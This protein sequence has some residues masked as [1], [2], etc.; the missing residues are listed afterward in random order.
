MA[1]CL[2]TGRWS[3]QTP[4]WIADHIVA[5]LVV[6]PGA[7][8]VE[9]ALHVGRQLECDLLEEL[10]M[11]S[12][13]VF[14]EEDAVHLQVSIDSL[15]DT[16]RR[17][18]KVY[19]RSER[20][21]MD[22]VDV[23][24]V[25]TRHAS[26]VL[27]GA[28]AGSPEQAALSERAAAL[29]GGDWPP[30]GAV[31]VDVDG[32]Y[33][34]MA[35]IGFDYGPA[36][37][38]VRSLWRHGE[39]VLVEASLPEGERSAAAS[40][41]I[42]PALL[43][44]VLQGMV[45]LNRGDGGP[46]GD[47]G[48]LRLP[49]AFNGVRLFARGGALLRA[50]LTPLGGDAMSM[51]AVDE[52]GEV[53]AS[54]LSL[55]PRAT[56]R[57][58]LLDARGGKRESL[59]GLRWTGLA[60]AS[61][62]ASPVEE[63]AVLSA[64]PTRLVEGFGSARPDVYKDFESL[65][66]AAD[67]GRA[68]PRVVVF[69][70]DGENLEAS[71]QQALIAPSAQ[72]AHEFPRRLLVLLQRWLVDERFSASSLVLVTK[73]A[74]SVS[75]EEDVPGLTQTPVWGLVRSAQLEHPGRFVLV[76]LD[77][78][79]GSIAALPAA[80][81]SEEPQIAIRDGRQLAPRLARLHVAGL[82][83][84]GPW[85]RGEF[86]PDG[87]I[88]ITGGTGALGALI[89]RRLVA[90]HGARRLLLA[91]RHGQ[92]AA[93]AKELEIELAGLGAQVRIEACDVADRAQLES[94][95]GSIEQDR[96]LTAVLHL[97]GV[98][99]DGTITSLSPERLDPVLA[100]KVDAALHL[101]ELTSHLRLAAFV[102]FSSVTGTLGSPGQAGYAAAN[103]FLDGLAAY[104]R[105]RGLPGT[106][107]AW[108][109]W[110]G[111]RGMGARLGE[112]DLMR[113]ERFGLV[114]LS[115]EEGLELCDLA[116]AADEALVLP[117][118]LDAAALRTE[119]ENRSLHPLLG[120]LVR[121][122]ARGASK[123]TGSLARRLLELAE[124][125]REA[126]ML[127]IVR[128]EA[129]AV[130]GAP[131]PADIGAR[132]QLKELGFDSLM[133]VE[134]RNRLNSATGLRLPSTL[135]FD[136]P[137]PAELA[138][139]LAAELS[140]GRS[141][142]AERALPSV[143]ALP[144]EEPIA[145]VGMSCRYPG[146]VR[147]PD[148]L[149]ELLASNSD[150]IS[151]FPQDRGWD[152][153]GLYDPDAA[154]PGTSYAREGGFLDDAAEF[155]AA[156][157]GISPREALAMD[158]QQRVLLEA[159]WEALENARIDPISLRGSQTGVFAGIAATD[160][161][162]GLWAAPRGLE[163]LAG[164]WLTGS[165]GSIVSGRVAYVLGLEGPAV[166]VD[167]AC[168]SSLVAL[169]LAGQALRGG[170]CTM[171]LAGGVT[172]MDSPG[173]FAQFSGQR[174]LARDGRC[175][176]FADSADGVGWGE[177]VGIVVLERLSEAQRHGHRVLALLSASAV[178]Q[179]GASNGLT[180]PNGPSQ[181]RVIHQALARAGLSPAQVDAVEGHGTGTTLGDPIEAQALIATYGQGRRHD[182]PLWL[183]SIK[184][185]IGHTAAA[186]GVAGVI[187]MTMALQ[188]KVLPA[189]LH[190]D[191]PSSEVDWST[192]SVALLTEARP[193]E[194]N[195]EPRRA[196]V[197]S[198]GISGT[199][200]HVI[201]QE[202]PAYERSP[203][204]LEDSAEPS[205]GAPAPCLL[206]AGSEPGLR[207]QARRLLD[208]LARHPDQ[209]IAD[210]GYSLTDRPALQQR[211]VVLA[212][213][214]EE[215]ADGLSALAEGLAHATLTR[216]EAS[217][218]GKLAFLFTGQGAQRVGM[219]RGLYEAYS[220]FA[221]P[222]ERICEQFGQPLGSSVLEL[223][224]GEPDGGAPGSNGTGVQG[225]L[226][227]TGYAQPAL[228]AFEVALF[229][230]IETWGV[231]PD[232][233]LGHS[234]GELVAAHV[235]GVLS[236]AD[237][238]TLVAARGR[239]MDALPPGGAMAAV[240][241][242]E[243]EALGS[244]AEVPGSVALAAVNGPASVVLSG[245]EEAISRLSAAWELRGRKTRRL[246]V[247][248][249]FHSP[250]MD[251]ML[252][253]FA[254]EARSV[255]LA[256]PRI[257][258]VSNVTG[259]IAGGEMCDPDYWARHARE[260]VR[261]ADG[262]RRLRAAGA[263]YLLE[264]GPDG[265]LSAMAR[266]CLP[267]GEGV[268]APLQRRG[269]SEVDT[270][271]AGLAEVWTRG[272]SVDWKPLWSAH[273]ARRLELPTYAFQRSRY[274]LDGTPSTAG[275]PTLFGQ[276]SAGHPLL[277]ATVSL[278]QGGGRL[279]TGRVSL[280]THAWLADHAVLGTVLMPGTALVE[281]AL[282]AG[283][284]LGCSCLQELALEAPLAIPARGGVQLQVTVGEPD[285]SGC[286]SVSVHSRPDDPSAEIEAHGEDLWIRHAS[287]TL[288][289]SSARD[290]DSQAASSEIAR[291]WPPP[292]AEPL[293]IEDLYERLGERG[294]AY[295]P[296]FQGV[297]AAWR[298]GA[299]LFAEVILPADQRDQAESFNLHPALLDA[300]LHIAIA[301]LT[302]SGS[303]GG[304]RLPFL[305]RGVDLHAGGASELLVCLTPDGEDSLSLTVLDR[306]GAPV[307]DID[308]LRSRFVEA[309]QLDGARSSASRSLFSL[310]WVQ[311]PMAPA[312]ASSDVE[313]VALDG[314]PTTET[315]P[316]GARE[317][318]RAALDLLRSRL[319]EQGPP[320]SRFA[321][322]TQGALLAG[323]D[324]RAPSLADAAVWGLARGAQLEHPGRFLLVDVD[325]E[326]R[327][328][329]ALERVLDAAFEL[330][331]SQLAVRA[332]SVLVPRLMAVD[333]GSLSAEVGGTF[334]RQGGTVLVTGG[335]GGLGAV[336][337]R[338]LVRK[339][340]VDRLLL[341]GRRGLEAPG[342]GRLA[343]ELSAL[344]ANVRVAA[345]DVS[346]RAE[347]QALLASVEV[348][349]PLSGMVHAAGVLDDGVIDSL[350]AERLDGVLAPKL[351][352]A[353][354]LH[355]LTAGLDLDA[356]VSFSSIAG[357][358]GSPGQANY[359]A[360]NAF[361]DA[362]AQHR[363]SLG[364]PAVSLVWGAWEQDT[365]MT[366]GL[367]E[368]DRARVARAGVRPLSPEEG[369]QLFDLAHAGERA[370]ILAA[371]LDRS[372][373]RTQAKAGTL[374][375]ALR[376]IVPV[377]VRRAADVGAGSLSRLVGEASGQERRRIVLE[378]VRAETAGVLGHGSGDAIGPRQ[379]FKEL[380][381]D[382]L[383]A[384]ELRNR[385]GTLTGLSL[386][387]TLV[388]DYPNPTAL[389]DHLLESVSGEASR[390]LPAISAKKAVD[391]PIAI[392]GMSC[393]YP[394]GV[395]SPE[396]LWRLT[397]DGADAISPFP[398]DRGWNLDTLY[399]PDPDHPGT[400]YAMEGGFMRGVGDFD[401]EFFG[402]GPRE[403]LA[404][405]P[406]QRLL[407]EVSWEALEDAGIAPDSLRGSPTGVFAGVMYQDYATGLADSQAA[408]LEGYRATGGAGSV[409]SGRVAYTLGLE[410]P[411]VSIDTACSSSLVALHWAC[412][413]LASGECSM[414]LASGVTVLWTPGVFVEFSRQ[415]GL[416]RDGRCK[417]Y[418]DAAD[419][420]GW[421]E[422]VGVLVL[423]RL[424]EAERKGHS[425]LAV[426]RGSAVNQDGASNGLAAPNGPSQQNVIH[427]ALANARVA[428]EQVDVVEGHGTGTML[429]DPIEA[430]ALLATYGQS[431]PK[432]RPLWLGS[433]KS[434][435][436]HTQAA[437]GVAGVIKMAMAM[438]HEVLP[439][440][441]HVEQ[442]S[443]E[444][445]WSA[446]A[447]SLLSDQ[448]PWPRGEQT[449]RAGVS[450]FG[451]SGT[452][453]H[454][455]LEEPP[456][457]A[458][459]GAEDD[460][461]AVRT[462]PWVLSGRSAEALR[463][464][465]GRL[466]DH[467]TG[468]KDLGVADV[469][470]SLTARSML[471]CRAVVVGSDR[472]GLLDGVRAVARGERA[473]N[474]VRG[475]YEGP[476]DSAAGLVAFLFTGQGA[477]HVG[478]GRELYREL[479]LYRHAFDETCA[480]LEEHLTGSVKE[481]VLGDVL[482]QKDR[483]VEANSA[484]VQAT[485]SSPLDHTTLAQAA[486]F[487]LEVALFRVLES[488]GVRPDFLIGHSVGELAAA[489]VSGVF[490][491]EDAC[492]LVAARGRLM[493][494]L[495]PGGAMV[496]VQASEQEALATLGDFEGSVTL[497]AVNGPSSVVL[498][499]DEDAVSQLT[500]LW[501]A[502]SRKTKRLR[503]SHAFH[504]HHMDDMLERF[505]E[506]ATEVSFESPRIPIVSNLTGEP[507]GADLLCT[508]D[509]WVRH[510]RETVRFGDG[511]A[512]LGRQG[513][514]CLLELGPD[515]VLSAMAGE[516]LDEED[517][518]PGS[519]DSATR[520]VTAPLL[521]GDRPEV[522]TLVGSLAEAFVAG[523]E[524]DWAST[525]AE[526]GARRV[527]LPT[528]AFQR[529][530]YWVAP[531]SGGGDVAAVGQSPDGHPLLGAA[532]E[533]A[534]ERGGL[535]TGRISVQTHPWLADHAAM[536]SVLL[537]GMAY[538]DLA[539][540]AGRQIGADLVSEL[541][542]EVP[543]VMDEH[544]SVLLQVSVGE[545]DELGR[546]TVD[547][548]SRPTRASEGESWEQAWTRHAS[549]TLATAVQ[550]TP[551][552]LGDPGIDAM[553]ESWPPRG[554]ER[555]DITGAYERLADH[556]L[557][558]GPAFQG[559]R[560]VWRTERE[561]FA[562]VSLP[563]DQHPQAGAFAIH[564]ALLDAAFHAFIDDGV[565]ALEEPRPV[566]LPFSFG[567]VGLCARGAR[568]LRVRLSQDESS[569]VSL[570][571][572]DETGA[573]VVWVDSLVGREVSRE[574]L[575]SA[576]RAHRDSLFD[577]RWHPIASTDLPPQSAVGRWVVL[578]EGTAGISRA[579]R[580]VSI[581]P[582]EHHTAESLVNALEQGD[583]PPEV[584][585]VDC[586]V[587]L[588]ADGMPALLRL[589]VNRALETL[590]GWLADER[591]SG[592]RLVLLTR[593]A[594]ATE[595]GA[596][597]PGLSDAALW[598]LVQSAQ[599]ENPGR[600]VLVDHD[601]E[602]S[603]WRALAG[604]LAGGEPRLALR[605]GNVLVP[606]LERVAREASSAPMD[607]TALEDATAAQAG[608]GGTPVFDP[609]KT[610]LITGGTGGLGALM[611]RHLA[612]EHGARN[613][614]LA[615]RRG[616]EAPGVGEL[617]D[618][619]AQLGAETR[620]AACDV[621]VREQLERLLDSI[622]EQHPL[623]AVVHTAAIMDNGLV[624]SLTPEQIDRVLAAKAD[625]AW[626]LHE[627]TAELDLSAFVLFSSI[628]GLFGGPGQGNY[629]AANVFL[630]GLAVHRRAQGL[631][632]TSVAWSLWS[633]AGA[634]TQ[635]GQL[636][637]RRVVG[638]AGLS[639][640][641]SEQ[642]LE[643]FDLAVAG[644]AATVLAAPMDLSALRA[645]ARAGTVVPLLSGLVPV[646]A[647]QMPVSEEGPL[648][649]RLASTP[650]DEREALVL[651]VVRSEA[652]EVLGHA[653]HE[654]ID[655]AR[656]FKEAGFDSLAAV[657]L[658]NR[659][660]A[661]TGLRLPAT[662]VF[663]RPSPR[664]L[665]GYLLGEMAQ[666]M[667]GSEAWVEKA[668][669]EVERTIAQLAGAGPD[670]RRVR[671][672]LNVC[673]AALGEDSVEQ[674]HAEDDFESATDDEMFEI[675]DTEL[676]SS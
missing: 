143:A 107:L 480:Q 9:L 112:A 258:V 515:G 500:E 162:A 542:L 238:C 141:T 242:S 40:Y 394:G 597:V 523:V 145:I 410:G 583:T 127:D 456:A 401:C 437:A 501:E 412:Q 504:S 485:Q 611:A 94:L 481:A 601:G 605:S 564:P 60:T 123:A 300:A 512:W 436:G 126:A 216:A 409:V 459:E 298:R 12:P 309:R 637:V 76:D 191:R 303:D 71:G 131:S 574:Q 594:V 536:G 578:G 157:F 27:A 43:D 114:A 525:F 166:S 80:S 371:S 647:R 19:S 608:S 193:W 625:A 572:L 289:P 139:Y 153:E 621:G 422:G 164:Y 531:Q 511:I 397:L 44:A 201:L 576:D 455:I 237:A 551:F 618:E 196:G 285:E 635:L 419:G 445:D 261:F 16:G 582:E 665:A 440:T 254:D 407:L 235:A 5:G 324:D 604:A 648:A 247:S 230:L 632:A 225:T 454:V 165:T 460:S 86:D 328:W 332:G 434:N 563:E 83:T 297:R 569:A 639:V 655:P 416:A 593:G 464:Q 360:A 427:Q 89:A 562:E 484:A 250:H 591:L 320:V 74:V 614:L 358:L 322:V 508:A 622:D 463:S 243:E 657:E 183:G 209:R 588:R 206:S 613:L 669:D 458:A 529:Q 39:D 88:L 276:R 68:V 28:D 633:E 494:E 596:D 498:S 448:V 356:F 391:E 638:S 321:L 393:R 552:A 278:A 177:G 37:L 624:D 556:G 471:P 105:A 662:L 179:D 554:A 290:A 353:W 124:D 256:E 418:A 609:E 262:V 120:D 600:F 318:V 95:L 151:S 395:S 403:A 150:A 149:W 287:G 20:A 199:N 314:A 54:M 439:R 359:G 239:L 22:G 269:R 673:V 161:G 420:T 17:S 233:L 163:N 281:L 615:S 246:A 307:A 234:I 513:V 310:E 676:G 370:V 326:Q 21:A 495:P 579:L 368:V 566:H 291:A 35:T 473:P 539:L 84:E 51:V 187:K 666:D 136:H 190:V 449:R 476:V 49:F 210:I 379:S 62:A 535:F 623:G 125:E 144:S 268:V 90:V 252:A 102:M 185:N 398:T 220:A 170:E 312:P 517:G 413:A 408:G 466:V 45:L 558:Y 483:G 200:A 207:A 482:A 580:E 341:V 46:G 73:G 380:G 244:L 91:S 510:V 443:G 224:I 451:L 181:Q 168:S 606:R 292:G 8:F 644:E 137:S 333:R 357:T 116:V 343:E 653:S 31:E 121:V 175:K 663:D 619:L 634:G 346:V 286:R 1:E 257:P 53:A 223:L 248:H 232:L 577:V 429:G 47:S 263:G 167:T 57:E 457:L 538:L 106:S 217:E 85:G 203:I 64:G 104:R 192:G 331:E 69:D 363:R 108:G 389:A 369:L 447:V 553:R 627:L 117:V 603:S 400:S 565:R 82:R 660:G 589:S 376:G 537:P 351:D 381:F 509:Y 271:L 236:L 667:V 189:T 643:L 188:R 423:E 42:H 547:I 202:A 530:R 241:A 227:R 184:S 240:Q 540:H 174:G 425:V 171:A 382:S 405:D 36:F 336:L 658:R 514:R 313:L 631:A 541:T 100:G 607:E 160:F 453:A 110:A 67:G 118:R 442:P 446:G 402:I 274:W 130:L 109:L 275:R 355:E 98:L 616:A 550:P 4:A 169:H 487:A 570:M 585:L 249:A 651:T 568:S 424:S 138:A 610:V 444:V 214:R 435:I 477:Q 532:V 411:A 284:E 672:R 72:A 115:A 282:H 366:S 334:S 470:Y 316:A 664:E 640:L 367:D 6:V 524:L 581:D 15:D 489:H 211:A 387:A 122:P 10:V 147:S 23:E 41:G 534:G 595:Q 273:Q 543:L 415:R 70:C 450:S 629:A 497:A 364:L 612:A 133:A 636:D 87:T 491:L 38:G 3:L 671:A 337:A 266:E 315:F 544:S 598:G 119:A 383:A 404:I 270:L 617:V 24:A 461:P 438:R 365:G 421:S 349:H 386:S 499:G 25:W 301:D 204:A 33:A 30:Q 311:A 414:A 198:F 520:I 555:V 478:M 178:N 670:S 492:M 295:G 496:A 180:A 299:E 592:C 305:W 11:E 113:I 675:L 628:A 490:S 620:V 441:L 61:R 99:D 308:A 642:G 661:A 645:E 433:V 575:L 668:L 650:E 361:L 506:A 155:D 77:G 283:G 396:E 194:S 335:T 103:A 302:Q 674:E 362:L 475:P 14:P 432:E 152:L 571:A 522:A 228:F 229:R 626:H 29:T 148:D 586:A 96:P 426:V 134:L 265:V 63:W 26:F 128:A 518:V 519:E 329:D 452:N 18:A 58:R 129:A 218:G 260:T 78:E 486:L 350:S 277:G 649:R 431:R 293:S 330:G 388:F 222:L 212:S 221:E 430:Q 406:Q 545:R 654:A 48:D 339:H 264:L 344:G 93:G 304:V 502:R 590:Q 354:H 97:A 294:L 546:R 197:S 279:L 156:F 7:A 52:H 296:A 56:S 472:D 75:P 13:L 390:R 646:S 159:S 55:S 560:A 226:D 176:S 92:A 154:T 327:S 140:D 267:A 479:A 503:V 521:R 528:Y 251:G 584:A 516:I 567:E 34:H 59:F 219:G 474:V 378:L 231:K 599:T 142:A 253:Q 280:Q 467:L 352:G 325:G 205:P 319:A 417:S 374:P 101:H 488:W 587:A 81:M 288:R 652:A 323:A 259:E 338:H 372:A 392:V 245:D 255:S 468:C 348:E 146:G 158:P 215:L 79:D 340:G 50:R 428:P 641:T 66:V 2:F 186:S 385:L 659:L 342:A 527:G 65:C 317:R 507:V 469:G 182:R 375:A 462:T 533:L 172:V 561:L 373:L 213:G 602:Q 132:G 377:P 32:F 549:G 505:A 465:A 306:N 548:Y 399:H 111:A 135:V 573:P 384:I 208:H 345:C 526:S 493:G 656:A 173:L 195:G 559:L 630:D 272:A 557:E 347:V